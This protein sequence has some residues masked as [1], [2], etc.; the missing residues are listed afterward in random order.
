M[1]IRP[2]LPN[3]NGLL[4]S[5]AMR[6]KSHWGYTSEM[7][8]AFEDELKIS[9]SSLMDENI[10]AFVGVVEWRILGFYLIEVINDVV[11]LDFLFIEPAYIGRGFGKTL[12]IH[13][14]KYAKKLGAKSIE[15]M[16]DPNAKAFFLNA[17]GILVGEQESNT[18]SGRYLPLI[19]INI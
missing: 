13:A 7:M 11:E 10:Y 14:K 12:L 19:T 1:I 2:A 5:L 8:N 4:S 9:K 15:V 17:G 3:E 18:I 16:S 6:S